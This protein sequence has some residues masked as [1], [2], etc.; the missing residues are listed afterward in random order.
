MLSYIYFLYVIVLVAVMLFFICRLAFLVD[1]FISPYMFLN[2]S[3]LYRGREIIRDRR[4][5][6]EKINLVCKRFESLRVNSIRT[7]D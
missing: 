6:M 2:M 4:E 3:D 5:R 7:I 1:S